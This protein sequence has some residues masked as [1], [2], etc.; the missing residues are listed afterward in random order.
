MCSSRFA[1]FIGMFCYFAQAI[2]GPL[3]TGPLLARSGHTMPAGHYDFEPYLFYTDNRAVFGRH[4]NLVHVPTTINMQANPLLTYGLNNWMD[5][6]FLFP[7]AINSVNMPNPYHRFSDI[8]VLMGFQLIEQHGWWPDF[9]LSIAETLP[10]GK[11]E[12]A[13][14]AGNNVTGLGSYQTTIGLNFQY[15]YHFGGERYLRTR[16]VADY[17]YASNVRIHGRS[18]YGGFPATKGTIHLG[19]MAN[20][21]LAFEYTWT[22]HWAVVMEGYINH[23]QSTHFQGIIGNPPSSPAKIGH[24]IVNEIT[25]APAI[26][27]NWNEHIGI[28]AGE[29]FTLA[30]QDTNDFLSTVVAI[31]IFW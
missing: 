19:Y 25:L 24:Q 8:T 21:D 4:W 23:R 15:L 7:Y 6:Q 29:W 20:A 10:T 5:V 12:N 14:Q 28:I 27:Y 17:N 2:S 13:N 11:Y 9:R 31:N 30:G 26:E 16:F 3:F 22:R 1:L 18:T